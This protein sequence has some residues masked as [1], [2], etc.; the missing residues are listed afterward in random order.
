MLVGVSFAILAA[1]TST[2]WWWMTKGKQDE[3]QAL[4]GEEEE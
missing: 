3:Y 1:I 2:A 4:E